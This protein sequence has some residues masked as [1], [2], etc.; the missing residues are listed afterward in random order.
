MVV[1]PSTYIARV[2]WCIIPIILNSLFGSTHL[3]F[4]WEYTKVHS[5]YCVYTLKWVSHIDKMSFSNTISWKITLSVKYFLLRLIGI[6]ASI[7]IALKSYQGSRVSLKDWNWLYF[8]LLKG[9]FPSIVT[10]IFVK[11]YLKFKSKNKLKE[12]N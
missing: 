4:Q 1:C 9:L 5:V 3:Y 11:Q 7:F 10:L 8:N 6:K 2:F 12:Q